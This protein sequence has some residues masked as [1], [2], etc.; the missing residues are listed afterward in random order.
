MWSL[1]FE[2]FELK[3]P[4]ELGL[5]NLSQEQEYIINLDGLY[6]DA[7]NIEKTDD[8]VIQSIFLKSKYNVDINIE[9][10]DNYV[11]FKAVGEWLYID[12]M[13]E[14]DKEIFSL[15]KN[16]PISFNVLFNILS[17][18]KAN[19]LPFNLPDF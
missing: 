9:Q 16:M 18:Y 14:K 4:F 5:V 13:F 8:A 12:L 2:M 11:Y 7:L 6:V 15:F 19:K 17:D 1:M 3:E 10:E